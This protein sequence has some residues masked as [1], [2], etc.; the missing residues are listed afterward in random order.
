[1]KSRVF[2]AL[3]VGEE[4]RQWL[5]EY[6]EVWS[7]LCRAHKWVHPDDYHITLQFIGDVE[8][9]LLTRLAAAAE[10]AFRRAPFRLCPD[11]PGFFGMQNAPKV[12]WYGVQGELEELS[13]L[14][15]ELGRRLSPLGFEP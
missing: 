7:T 2:F 5:A 6:T 8:Q 10:P 13:R 12:L 1:P 14:H 11:R 9:E 4:A 3:P 15:K